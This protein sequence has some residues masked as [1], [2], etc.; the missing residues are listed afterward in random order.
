MIRVL[1]LTQGTA[2]PFATLLL[3]EAGA[4][5][6]KVEQTAGSN[7][8]GAMGDQWG[9]SG[10][11]ASLR[12]TFLNRRKRSITLNLAS[13]RGRALFLK[14]A[15]EAD[16]VVEDFQPGAIAKLGLSFRTLRRANPNLVLASIS[17]FGQTGPRRD[18]VASELVLQAMGGVVDSTGKADG[19]PLRLA[20]FQAS[21]IAGVNAA[22]ATLAAVQG[23]RTGVERG[24]QI[25]IAIQETFSPH[26]VRHIEQFIYSGRRTV[27]GAGPQV[28]LGYPDIVRARDGYIYLLALR[29][30]WESF[31]HFLGLE[32]YITHEWSEREARE[33]HWAE[34]EARFHEA[35][36]KRDREDW[37]ASGVE[38]GYTFAPVFDADD[39]LA[40]AHL[41][42]RGFFEEGEVEGATV[43]VA[44]LP[45][46]FSASERRANVAP[47]RGAH[48]GEV[49]R[50]L[51]GLD[52]G[53][54]E[55]LQQGGVI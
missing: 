16:A 9:R 26:C 5:V 44:G 25:D 40:S 4:D 14:L 7:E 45:F 31:A 38:H 11:D 48:N 35:V 20:G 46:S 23:V 2:G 39:V 15:A 47:T 30:E 24:V 54:I 19:P 50:A 33:A 12:A 53:A 28:N 27:R 43:R 3:A 8:L 10:G 17:N 41:A 51:L 36:A 22:T 37:V 42:A 52:Q 1:D 55:A 34:I 6:I 18:W 29:A 13:R 21:Y 49:Y 32:E